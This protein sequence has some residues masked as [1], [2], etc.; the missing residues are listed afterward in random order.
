MFDVMV[1]VK[2]GHCSLCGERTEERYVAE[3]RQVNGRPAV[4]LRRS[5][6]H[7]ATCKPCFLAVGKHIVVEAR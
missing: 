5:D 7:S 2:N 6:A 3:I 4:T 1:P